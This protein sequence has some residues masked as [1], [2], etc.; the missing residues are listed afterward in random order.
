M[1]ATQMFTWLVIKFQLR[2]TI[3]EDFSNYVV[4]ILANTTFIVDAAIRSLKKINFGFNPEEIA[5]LDTFACVLVYLRIY[6]R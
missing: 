1:I 5:I 3:S 6:V 2:R 4:F